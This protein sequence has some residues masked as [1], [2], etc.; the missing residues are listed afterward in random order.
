M[1]SIRVVIDSF[2]AFHE[3]N[4]RSASW[5]EISLLRRIKC[6]NLLQFFMD[7]VT[8]W[9]FVFIKFSLVIGI[10]ALFPAFM[11]N[12][13]ERPICTAKHFLH[14]DLLLSFSIFSLC[15][16]IVMILFSALHFTSFI[17]LCLHTICSIFV[18]PH[19]SRKNHAIWH[20][21]SNDFDSKSGNTLLM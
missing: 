4:W 20:L 5:P 21:L 18:Q 17:N 12:A 10:F 8:F 15:C 2:P 7:L 16:S 3:M 1:L 6:L 9:R 11:T 13:D 19:L 14:S